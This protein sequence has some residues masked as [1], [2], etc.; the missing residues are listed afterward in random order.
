LSKQ[1]ELSQLP[2]QAIQQHGFDTTMADIT[3]D[4]IDGTAFHDQT[5]AVAL[6]I[7]G[8]MRPKQTVSFAWI[9]HPPSEFKTKHIAT[10]KTTA[11]PCSSLSLPI[12]SSKLDK[13]CVLP[14]FQFGIVRVDYQ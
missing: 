6:S 14:T 1:L 3:M 9:A 2:D 7:R 5:P 13:V 8:A 10:K 12:Q 11:P 4:G